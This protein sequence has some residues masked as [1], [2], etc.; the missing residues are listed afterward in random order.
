MCLC[1]EKG[2]DFSNIFNA[3]NVDKRMNLD[4]WLHVHMHTMLFITPLSLTKFTPV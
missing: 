4:F 3:G 1:L 2:G